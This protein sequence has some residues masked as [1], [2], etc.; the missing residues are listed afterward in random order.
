MTRK[1]LFFASLLLLLAL[2][3]FL[4]INRWYFE[5]GFTD[6]SVTLNNPS[7]AITSKNGNTYIIDTSLRRVIKRDNHK[8]LGYMLNGGSRKPKE[9][10]YA[11]EIAVDEKE[12]LYL[13][14][15]VYSQTGFHVQREEILKYDSQGRYLKTIYKKEYTK[16]ISTRVQRGQITSLKISNDR[17]LW[18]DITESGIELHSTELDTDTHQIIETYQ[19]KEANITLSDVIYINSNRWIMITKRGEIKDIDLITDTEYTRYNAVDHEALSVP[20]MLASN[21]GET[22]FFSDIARRCI[23]KLEGNTLSTVLDNSSFDETNP[24]QSSYTFY[25]LDFNKNRT[26]T[27]YTEEHVLL[28]SKGKIIDQFA[29]ISYS[30]KHI[31]IKS[32]L[33]I[34]LL[35][36][37]ICSVWVLYYTYVY[38]F[39]SNLPPVLSRGITVILIIAITSILII[40]IILQNFSKRYTDTVLERSS[41]MAQ[42]I[43]HTLDADLFHDIKNQSDYMGDSYRTIRSDMHKALNNNQ[44]AWNDRYYFALYRVI[45]EEL[46]G[47]MFLNDGISAYHPFPYFGYEDGAYDLAYKGEI[48]AETDSDNLGTW[49]YAVGPVYDSGGE[50]VALIEIGTDLFSFTQENRKLYRQIILE[51]MTLVVIFTLLL[52]E[53]AFLGQI[54]R[55]SRDVNSSRNNFYSPAFYARPL[56]FMVTTAISMSIAFVPVMMK[57]LQVPLYGIP[58]DVITALPI[59]L[60]MLFFAIALIIGGQFTQRGHWRSVQGIGLFIIAMG[61]LLSGLSTNMYVFMIARAITGLGSGLSFISFRSL[62]NTEPNPQKRSMSYSHFYVGM[63]AGVN[64][65][66]IFGSFLADQFDF[67]RVFFSAAALTLF[68]SFIIIMVIRRINTTLL[69]SH[70]VRPSLSQVFSFLCSRKVLIYFLLSILPTYTAGMFLVYYFPLFAHQQGFSISDIGRLFIVNGLFVI[71]LG[72]LL[73][74][75]L[76]RKT[77][78]K[79]ALIIGSLGWA[80]ALLIFAVTGS[81]A[82][83]I[84]TLV[85]MGIVEGFCVTAQNDYFMNLEQVAHVGEDNAAAYLEVAAKIAEIAA[86]VLFGFILLVGP[87]KGIGLLAAAIFIFTI[88]FIPLSSNKKNVI[89]HG[90]KVE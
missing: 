74:G 75:V 60:E 58:E 4:Y 21:D 62:V 19:L 54:N 38:L 24:E 61:L 73:S 12:N 86:P 76:K 1:N 15:L 47:F 22:L 33:F 46:Y 31:A 70:R 34:S 80:G 18:F 64:V 57:N 40:T 84:A 90:E 71:Y 11:A 9:F 63:I 87:E 26:I 50:L 53:L 25:T 77:S 16:T 85:V 23:S 39:K 81:I 79:K 37:L 66:V 13:L 5:H 48:I 78:D 29:N 2:G 3:S 6:F 65:G 8:R 52:I 55:M 14:N 56:N 68:A 10:F 43:P 51:V 35:I 28:F 67:A 17:L 88:L 82:G 44:N 42:L 27:T 41:Q 30:N 32:C 36:F 49:I 7:H 20:Y 59:S 72:P 89:S 83:A 45:D 69:T